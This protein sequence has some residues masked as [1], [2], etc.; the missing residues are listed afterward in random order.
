MHS[1]GSWFQAGEQI[2]VQWGFLDLYR[3]WISYGALFLWSWYDARGR[4]YPVALFWAWPQ[5]SPKNTWCQLTL[6]FKDVPLRPHFSSFLNRRKQGALRNLA[7]SLI[8]YRYSEYTWTRFIENRRVFG[9]RKS[10]AL[11]DQWRIRYHA[12]ESVHL[13]IISCATFQG[14]VDGASWLKQRWPLLK[15]S[16]KESCYAWIQA[17]RSNQS[18]GG[19]NRVVPADNRWACEKHCRP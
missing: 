16:V 11:A 9:M 14:T 5:H 2:A 4:E 1:I 8:S 19:S 12:Q 7:F 6:L 13:C 18:R 10:E 15:K 3:H 17:N